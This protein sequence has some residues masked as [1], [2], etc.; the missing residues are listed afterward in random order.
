V[1]ALVSIGTEKSDDEP[2]EAGDVIEFELDFWS[3]CV[4]GV[5]GLLCEDEEVDE[6]DGHDDEMAA[7]WRLDVVWGNCW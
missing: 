7:T 1:L 3:D 4:N 5:N 6:A 2:E